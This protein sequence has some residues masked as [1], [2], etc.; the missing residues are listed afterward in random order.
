MYIRV[1]TVTYDPA[2]EE[3]VLKLI[4]DSLIPR[5]QEIS[6]FQSYSGGTNGETGRGVAISVWDSMDHAAELREVLGGLIQD[7]ERVGVGFEPA[8]L[9]ELT[10]QVGV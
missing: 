4:D 5:F 2:R 6:G 7:F 8:Q 10:R 9:F 3:E 1:T